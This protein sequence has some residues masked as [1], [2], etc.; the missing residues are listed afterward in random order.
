MGNGTWSQKVKGCHWEVAST[1]QEAGSKVR[2]VESERAQID[3]A[4]MSAITDFH[5]LFTHSPRTLHGLFADSSRTLRGLFADSSRT[6]RGLFADFPRTLRGLSADSQRTL[7]GLSADSSRTLRG[8]FADL[9]AL[10]AQTGGGVD[11][12]M[13]QVV[14]RAAGV[15][16]ST[17]VVVKRL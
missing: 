17:C 3:F 11:A 8:L 1:K 12:A 16:P 2:Q 13:E 9:L 15:R 5:G 7:R 6:L 4:T 10:L 14:L